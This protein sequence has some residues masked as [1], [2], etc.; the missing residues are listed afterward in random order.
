MSK[1]IETVEYQSLLVDIKTAIQKARLNAVL[2]INTQMILLYWQ[3]GKMIAERQQQEG[4]SAK[5]IPRLA[6]DLKNEFTDLKGFSERNLGRM[7][8]FYREYPGTIILPQPMAKL[9]STDS[10]SHT[11][12]PQAVA[13]LQQVVAKIPWGH[14][15]LLIEKVKDKN[16]RLWYAQQTI[17]KNWSRDL[18][19]NAIKMD[20]YGRAKNQL[21]ANNFSAT[22]PEPGAA[23][24]NEVF[25]SSY[26]LGF[27]GI[28]EPVKEMELENR[29]IAKIRAF[30]LELG[31]GFSFIG[32]QYRL[33][34]NGKEYF[35]DML[36]FHRGLQSL[37]AI[38]LKIGSF[39]AEYAGKM[40][41][42]LS[43]LNKLE[44]GENENPS[45]GIILCAD[46]DHLDV[47]IALQ[48]INKP[49]GVAEYQLLLP[50]EELQTLVLNEINTT[51]EENEQE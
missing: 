6:V 41:L 27:L 49:I 15:I 24:A 13:N 20:T 40:N 29:L 26:N 33:E 42:Y 32:N 18:L 17:E 50:K 22:L 2:A 36:F 8:A 9:Q 7:L 19:L 23:Y 21:K 43:L 34:Y 38:E 46:K 1:D 51:E 3:T 37:V 45:V 48:D 39:K 5:V 12:L 4:W 14:N 35:V 47:E 31:K 28:T 25:K 16:A 44:K 11:N 30:I 10:E